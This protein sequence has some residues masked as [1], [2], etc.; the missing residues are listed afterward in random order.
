MNGLN[1]YILTNIGTGTR[2]QN[3][4]EPSIGFTAMSTGSYT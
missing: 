4:T 2:D 3:T 1:Y